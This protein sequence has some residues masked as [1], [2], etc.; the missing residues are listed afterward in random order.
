MIFGRG[1]GGR[2]VSPECRGGLEE[3]SHGLMVG[4]EG[5]AAGTDEGWGQVMSAG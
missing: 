4:E 1:D 3:A 5:K 2:Q